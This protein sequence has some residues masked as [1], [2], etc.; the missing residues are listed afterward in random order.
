MR[1]DEQMMALLA[2]DGRAGPAAAIDPATM[3]AMI[4]GALDRAF[5]PG[6]GGGAGGSGGGLSAKL[7]AV[8]AAVVITGAVLVVWI[9]TSADDAIPP[10]EP[11]TE[12]AAVTPAPSEPE[13]SEV[14]APLPE[15]EMDPIKRPAPIVKPPAPVATAEDLLEK[16]NA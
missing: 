3:S 5:P 16:A 6:G 14:D 11:P 15:I 2:L 7:A 1:D 4:A 8:A 13:V 12:R 9:G 10:R